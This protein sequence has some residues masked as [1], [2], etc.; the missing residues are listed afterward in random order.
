MPYRI[1]L[2]SL[3]PILSNGDISEK[4]LDAFSSVWIH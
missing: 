3:K 1:C 2:K 4:H